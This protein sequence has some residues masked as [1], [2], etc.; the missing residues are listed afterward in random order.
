MAKPARR[1]A[2]IENRVITHINENTGIGAKI[3]SY[4]KQLTGR[5]LT[6]CRAQKTG[7]SERKADI[8]VKCNNATL[9]ISVKS[10]E[11]KADY[12]HVERGY[13]DDYRYKWNLPESVYKALKLF[14]GEVDEKGNPLPRKQFVNKAKEISSNVNL[15]INELNERARQGLID[16]NEKREL[17]KEIEK[18]GVTP[19]LIG[20]MRRLTFNQINHIDEQ[21]VRDVLNFFKQNKKFVV[22]NILVGDLNED[23]LFFLVVKIERNMCC[24]Y[25]ARASRVIEIYSQGEV[26][27]SKEGNLL[28]GKVELQRKG[29]NRWT[30]E[31]KW[32]D[33]AANQIQF[34][35]S[36]SEITR[37]F[38][39]VMI[40]CEMCYE[41]E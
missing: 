10:Y 28:I 26:T 25:I 20:K 21:L 31:R 1:G 32:W 38:N 9:Y 5:D 16:E 6:S 8:K 34:K 19:G 33:E 24:Y 35:I 40:D 4:L 12:N 39:T 18:K 36:P 23:C 22:K 14:V 2:E 3:V 11:P 27:I 7:K 15:I 17:M 41:H 37:D 30:K 13:V 29:G